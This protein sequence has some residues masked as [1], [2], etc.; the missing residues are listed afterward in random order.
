LMDPRLSATGFGSYREVKSGWQMG[1][2]VD[3]IRG[4]SFGGGQFPVFFPG[5]TTSQ[6][7]AS[8]S[9]NEYPDPL[10]ACSGYSM[11]TGLPVFIELGGNVAT[12]ATTSSFT[13]NGVALA[14]CVIDSTNSSLSSYLTERGGVILIPRQPLQSGVKYAVSLTVN[15]AP[16]AWS[17]SVGA[18]S[19][20]A[21]ASLSPS[22]A[23]SASVG[24]TVTL[25]A[26]STGC[27]NPRYA[28]WVQ[29]PDSSWHFAQD[30]G[31]P[32]FS[33]NTAGL[34]AGT[35]TVHVWVNTEG[36]SYDA[37][38]SDTVSLTGCS[39]ASLSPATTT[40]QLGATVAYTASSSGCANPRYA[41][42]VLY[43]DASWHFVQDFGGSAFNW[44]TVGL[45]AGAY[46][47][48][49]WV[50]TGGYAYDAIGSATATLTGCASA[51]LSPSTG[52]A[53]AGTAVAFTAS[54]TGCTNPRYAFWVQY[55]DGSWHF[56]QDFGGPNFSWST[57]GLPAGTYTVHVW[58]NTQGI[59]YDAIGSATYTLR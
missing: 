44:S 34:A 32:T 51:S 27:V 6:P 14:H 45:K 29:Y 10:Q 23:P 28:F 21:T 50:N 20:C 13:G 8:Y 5:N 16:Y 52:S 12:S 41:F 36:Y 24:S 9:G 37:I 22:P 54:S 18:F 49:A 31:G 59:Y 15:G 4:N 7:L 56:D 17:F 11:P 38:G 39:S 42:W 48:H 43:P 3:V 35:Y 1:A 47:I 55:P 30:F 57:T 2:T 53:A 40:A 33:W 58:V 25:T 26:S 46:T 19:A